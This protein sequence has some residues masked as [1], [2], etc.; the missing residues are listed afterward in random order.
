MNKHYE[1][2]S[3]RANF[4][5]EYCHAPESAFNFPF[6][7]DHFIPLAKGG[8]DD[9]DNLVFACRACNAYKAFHQLGLN[10][11]EEENLRLFNPRRDIWDKH[12]RVNLKTFELEGLTEVGSGTINRLK[13]NN[14]RQIKSRQLWHR[15]QIFP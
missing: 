11:E 6:E 10:D 1:A 3:K 12:F 5:C 13:I 7:V 4:L 14:A 9:L 15:S 8:T 2:V